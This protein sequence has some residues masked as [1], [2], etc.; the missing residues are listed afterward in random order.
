MKKFIIWTA[1]SGIVFLLIV[2]E[3]FVWN[4]ARKEIVYLCQNFTPGVAQESVIRQLD[5]GT[6]L[7]YQLTNEGAD[8]KIVAWS[9][10][11]FYMYQCRVNISQDGIVTGSRVN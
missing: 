3:G 9:G 5:T 11:N 4:E 2:V 7:R 8:R 6:F 10:V 1:L